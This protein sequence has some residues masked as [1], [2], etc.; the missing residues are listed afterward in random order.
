[1]VDAMQPRILL[2]HPAHPAPSHA[3]PVPRT[4]SVGASIRTS[5]A[6][7][8]AP[9]VHAAV[10]PIPVPVWR[11]KDQS[12]RPSFRPS[13]GV[14]GEVMVSGWMTT[15]RVTVTWQLKCSELHPSGICVPESHLVNQGPQHQSVSRWMLPSNLTGASYQS[16]N[17]PS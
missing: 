15:Y 3:I 14:C 1:M 10:S 16:I 5:V 11:N 13:G 9:T 2:I 7:T 12:V 8:I 17:L 6:P 4:V